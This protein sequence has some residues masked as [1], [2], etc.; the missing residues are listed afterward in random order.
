MASSND[1]AVGCNVNG[2]PFVLST[3]SSSTIAD[4]AQCSM[5]TEQNSEF[6]FKIRK[7]TLR[8]VMLTSHFHPSIRSI[9]LQTKGVTMMHYKLRFVP[10]LALDVLRLLFPKLQRKGGSKCQYRGIIFYAR[11]RKLVSTKIFSVLVSTKVRSD[12]VRATFIFTKSNQQSKSVVFNL[13][14]LLIITYQNKGLII[15][16]LSGI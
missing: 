10:I 3:F 11:T 14:Q 12:R 6:F 8:N 15:S 5:K 2:V 13:Q 9:E 1:K 4:I 16:K 7:A